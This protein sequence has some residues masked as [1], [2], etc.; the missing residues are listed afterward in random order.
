MKVLLF[1][2]LSWSVQRKAVGGVGVGVW[3][4]F[5]HPGH[6]DHNAHRLIIVCLNGGAV[7]VAAGAM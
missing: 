6:H 3:S 1:L 4:L 7:L 5:F 2:T